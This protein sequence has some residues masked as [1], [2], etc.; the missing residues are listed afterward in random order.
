MRAIVWRKTNMKWTGS[1]DKCHIDYIG[2]K[3]WLFAMYTICFGIMIMLVFG[4]FL[5]YGKSFVGG[6]DGFPQ[7]A[8]T[9]QYTGQ[10][11]RSLLQNI[12][13]GNL[14]L[15]M[16]DMSIGFG[17]N[18]LQVISFDPVYILCSVLFVHD[19]AVGIAAFDMLC[20]YL[21]GIVFVAL[22]Y[23]LGCN[24]Y[25]TLTAAMAYIFNGYILNYCMAQ[26][27]FLRLFVV[28]PMM[29]LG[30]HNVTKK[31]RYGI[32][33]LSVL[34]NIT[35]GPLNI[36]T[37]G[38][39]L[40]FCFCITYIFS[41]RKKGVADFFGYVWKPVLIYILAMFAMAVF[42][43]PTMYKVFSG[44]RIG[45]AS[46][47]FQ[48]LYD[49][50]YYRSLFHGLVGVDEIGIHG[51]IGVTTIS[52]LAI[53]C[54]AIKE[55]KSTLEKE[56]C[57]CGIAALLIA[58]FPIGS[59]LFNGGIGFNHR[60]LFII[61]FYLC[62]VLAVMLPKLF[63]LGV[64]EK[65]KLCIS[66]FVYIALYAV[67][68]V[69]S[70]KNVDYA[71]EFLLLYVIFVLFGKRV[72][73]Q[74]VL[75]M[76]CV[77]IA[78]FSYIVYE[79][80]QE[81]VIAKF[82][83]TKY[84]EEKISVKQLSILQNISDGE[85]C[86]VEDIQQKSTKDKDSNLGIRSGYS[87]LNGYYSFMYDDIISTMSDWGVS[88]TGAPFNVFDLDNRTALY[89]LGG[90]RY[91]VKEA[92]AKE[93]IPWG[94]EL[95]Y[96]QDMEVEG[97]NRTVQLYRNINALPLMYAY[98]GYVLKDEYDQL[99]P[100]E[101]E[102]AMM[103]GIVLE[104]Q[105][106][107]GDAEIQPEELQ[108]DS[109][110][111]L[112]KEEIL[113][114]IRE[115]LE[116]RMVE[117]ERSESPIEITDDGLICKSS[118]ITLTIELPE[119]YVGSESYLYLEGLRYYPENSMKYKEYLL[120]ENPTKYKTN[121]FYYKSRKD[122]ENSDLKSKI[123]TTFG[124]N[125]K[126]VLVWGK[127]SQYD[128]GKRDIVSNMGYHGTTAQTFTLQLEGRGEYHFS[129]LK[130]IVQP[131]DSYGENYVKLQECR[132]TDVQIHGNYVQGSVVT[133]TDRMLCIAI[134]YQKGWKAWVNGKE[135]KIVKANGMYMAI[136]LKAGGNGILLHYTIPGLKEGAM[137]SGITVLSLGVL[138]GIRICQK[139]RRCCKS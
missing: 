64:R 92:E 53:V 127:G 20:L 88:Q 86:R 50:S 80:S 59:Y 101:K 7:V 2:K 137:V 49:A 69:W 9:M 118:K 119:T 133:G 39:V 89:T 47:N 65:R 124:K 138:G 116:Q 103:Q 52:V 45:N 6:A 63:E 61:A 115:Q 22:C 36:Y 96:E 44:G 10:Y 38:I 107:I 117:E 79:P 106:D 110:V 112:D 48:W 28:L 72:K 81:N 83:N 132:S 16:W 87:A 1:Y 128:T 66:V 54:L 131:M 77:E 74:W 85:I 114:Q 13:Q 37:I 21:A 5:Y 42:L 25:A 123:T 105:S 122:T 84:L 23:N 3:R 62:I 19:I 125:K 76:I 99:K 11:Y 108:F 24:R 4:R 121:T 32:F 34:Y 18:I 78:V 31:N 90:V 111:V 120:G 139:K 68:S 14:Q 98:S 100:Y 17:M 12:L 113:Q 97:Q 134:P 26:N 58:V 35:L 46:I 93:S 94:Y 82:E 30:V 56:L 95:V 51:Y 29:L 41:T 67:V 71:M 136:P 55:K 57:V 135:T 102:Q 43:L 15:P 91:I 70:D 75:G 60:F 130:V 126:S 27:S 104:N 33:V 8:P 109:S 129:D 40:I 73:M